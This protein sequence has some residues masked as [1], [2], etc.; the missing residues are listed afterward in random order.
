MSSRDA[1]RRQ[2]EASGIPAS[3]EAGTRMLAYLELLE[4][5]GSRVN[6]TGSVEWT[7][8]G[9]LF[10]EALYAAG[11][12]PSGP[13]RHLDLGSGAGFPALPMRILRPLMTL[14]LVEARLKRA[15]FLETAVSELR[16]GGVEVYGQRIEAFLARREH[17]VWDS[18]SWKAIRME[19]RDLAGVLARRPV[20]IWVFHGDAFPG[21][22]ALILA[23][24]ERAAR[25]LVPGRRESY[26]TCYRRRLPKGPSSTSPAG[27]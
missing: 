9:P 27:S 23:T 19:E 15:V 12:F 20:E 1:L 3:S 17:E 2:L 10:E 4:K 24:H 5:W 26:V 7:T 16:L 21:D 18:V 11:L 25:S 6:L 14:D 13:V 8:L 22:E